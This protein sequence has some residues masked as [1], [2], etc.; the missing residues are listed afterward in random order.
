M[1]L[2]QGPVKTKDDFERKFTVEQRSFFDN[3]FYAARKWPVRRS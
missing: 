1:S 2:F 3:L